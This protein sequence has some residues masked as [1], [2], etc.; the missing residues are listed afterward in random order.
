MLTA[1]NSPY[2]CRANIARGLRDEVH[3]YVYSSRA[4]L[5][6]NSVLGNAQINGN[7]PRALVVGVGLGRIAYD[8]WQKFPHLDLVLVN[9]EEI[10]PSASQLAEE[11]S[12]TAD[13]ARVFQ[14]R[15]ASAIL[16]HDAN[17]RFDDYPDASFDLVMM[18]SMVFRYLQQKSDFIKEARRLLKPDG[19][20][21]IRDI[22]WIELQQ[23]TC[24]SSQAFIDHINSKHG[25]FANL[26]S[27]VLFID[28]DAEP[29]DDLELCKIQRHQNGG[30]PQAYYHYTSIYR[31][32]KL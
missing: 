1:V 22:N 14:Q 2:G 31:K 27:A 11:F 6:I 19:H 8:L 21:I 25:Y 24:S 29:I 13:E 7:P 16:Y 15:L 32:N 3:G 18:P 10:T 9:K 4:A 20:A 12:I 30:G 5:A 17:L 23:G 28:G 26:Y